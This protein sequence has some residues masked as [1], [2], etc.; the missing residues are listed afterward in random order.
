ME[1]EHADLPSFGEEYA[2]PGL[3]M[4]GVRGRADVRTSPQEAGQLRRSSYE[5]PCYS[6]SRCGH[7]AGDIGLGPGWEGCRRNGSIESC[8]TNTVG[9]S[10]PS[11]GMELLH[12]YAFGAADRTL[13]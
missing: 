12:H 11:G 1:N 10:G 6:D 13:R 4:R 9:R 3:Q 8:S 7:P 2:A 5:P